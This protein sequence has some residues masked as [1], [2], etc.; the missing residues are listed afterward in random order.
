MAK[1]EIFAGD[2]G[3][4]TEVEATMDE[5]VCKLSISSECPHI[6]KMAAEIPEVEPYGEISFRRA[7]PKIHEAGHKYCTHAS[8]PVPVGIIKAV[9]VEAGLALPT[10]PVIKLS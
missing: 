1:A 9:E 5:S 4:N 6:I 3:Y 8:C 7:M 2:C 10:N